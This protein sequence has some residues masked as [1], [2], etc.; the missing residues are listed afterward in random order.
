[1]GGVLEEAEAGHGPDQ[2]HRY[3]NRPPPGPQRQQGLVSLRER[4]EAIATAAPAGSALLSPSEQG[5]AGRAAGSMPFRQRQELGPSKVTLPPPN[6]GTFMPFGIVPAARPLSRGGTKVNR[7]GLPV[8]NHMPPLPP[9]KGTVKPPVSGEI[10]WDMS[11]VRNC[12]SR[13]GYCGTETM[14]LPIDRAL[15]NPSSPRPAK[16]HSSWTVMEEGDGP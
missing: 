10:Y 7:H 3:G 9:V 13:S 6:E 5:G 15:L 11:Q 8:S 14:S 1:M 2:R 4:A 16:C 12:P